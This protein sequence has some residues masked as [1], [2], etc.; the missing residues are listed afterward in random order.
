MKGTPPK[1]LPI[2]AQLLVNKIWQEVQAQPETGVSPERRDALYR[3][4]WPDIDL[5]GARREAM[6]QDDELL[7]DLAHTQFGH[8]AVA[9]ANHVLPIWDRF[10]TPGQKTGKGMGQE[11]RLPRWI[12]EIA[13]DV[14]KER[15]EPLKAWEMLGDFYDL[16]TETASLVP[17]PVWCVANSAYKT[18]SVILG[19]ECFP[20]AR[21]QQSA[22]DTSD[23]DPVTIA[24]SACVWDD[25]NAPGEWWSMYP[26]HQPFQFSAERAL[27][28]W[29]W[30][31][32]TAIPAASQKFPR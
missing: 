10:A 24:A 18:L 22:G 11:V 23:D 28:F 25:L 27:G 32:V 6:L 1:P 12:L 14:L 16:V 7:L 3:A 4:I 17:Y 13:Q 29:E 21:D 20:S 19:G 8:L 26:N 30:W 31:L 5:S 15:I 2:K 9:A